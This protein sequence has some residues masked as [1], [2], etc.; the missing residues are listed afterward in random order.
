MKWSK[1]DRE[2]AA[3]ALAMGASSTDCTV[4]EIW[5]AAGIERNT[6]VWRLEARAF[7][8]VASRLPSE[9]STVVYAEAEALLRTGWSPE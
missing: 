5:D 7:G 1:H 6:D 3:C 2:L 4:G 9:S 8:Y